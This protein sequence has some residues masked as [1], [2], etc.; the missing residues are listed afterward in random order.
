[1]NLVSSLEVSLLL[2]IISGD[3]RLHWEAC[4]DSRAH[5]EASGCSGVPGRPHG[6][7]RATRGAYLLLL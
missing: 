4:G 7:L 2:L 1:M 6:H 3:A 5:W